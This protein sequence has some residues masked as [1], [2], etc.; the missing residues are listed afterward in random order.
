MGRFFYISIPVWWFGMPA[1]LKGW[2]DKVFLYNGIYGG[3]FGKYESGALLGK[4]AM[5]SA[6]TS[7]PENSYQ[8]GGYSGDIHEQILFPIN[9]GMLHFSGMAP[10]EP[11]IAYSVSRSDAVREQYLKEWEEVLTNLTQRPAL[12]YSHLEKFDG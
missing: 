3:T 4:K 9:H 2:F 1:I 8:P 6:T 10:V 7:S 5:I 11:F 12:D